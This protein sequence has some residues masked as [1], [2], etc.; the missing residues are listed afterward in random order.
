MSIA[1]HEKNSDSMEKTV[2]QTDFALDHGFAT[3]FA[4]VRIDRPYVR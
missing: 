4:F 3:Q 2:P 1:F